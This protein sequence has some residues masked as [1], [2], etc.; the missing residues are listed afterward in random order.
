MIE[1]VTLEESVRVAR[2]AADLLD[3]PLLQAIDVGKRVR[4]RARGIPDTPA[5]MLVREGFRHWCG[6]LKYRTMTARDAVVIVTGATG[7]GKSTLAL[8]MAQDID[9]TFTLE[10]RLCYT[11]VE[12]LTI[13]ETIEEGQVVLFDEGVR[14][15]L[16][17]DQ[18]SA[19]Q[20]ALIQALALIREKGAVLFVCAPSIWNVA[21]QVRQNRAWMWIH[22]LGRGLALIH[23]R[24]DYL[25]YLPDATLGFS[26]SPQCPY[27]TWV[28]YDKK[29][30]FFK[31]YRKVKTEHLN[32]YLAETKDLLQGK[33]KKG[34]ANLKKVA[35]EIDKR[36]KAGERW[37]DIA[38]DLKQRGATT[39]GVPVAEPIVAPGADLTKEVS[40][41][42]IEQ[43]LRTMPVY[44]V[45]DA[46]HVGS[47]RIQRVKKQ[48]LIPDFVTPA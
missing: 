20:K 39:L 16:A 36:L 30:K 23:E 40:D 38:Q 2:D 6:S 34:A 44:K 19:E 17:G 37:E 5:P 22:V 8:R 24:N 3:S 1:E 9:P 31:E 13:Y 29:S 4:V 45:K 12:L 26:R 42:E 33:Q 21:K 43:A 46:L 28:P 11:A 47:E 32:K 7:E 14:G 10:K 27:M 15:L 35:V 18:M 41:D 48:R 25:H